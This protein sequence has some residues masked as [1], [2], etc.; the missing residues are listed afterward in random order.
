MLPAEAVEDL[1]K[2]LANLDTT[3]AEHAQL[4][5][6]KGY[7]SVKMLKNATFDDLKELGFITPV[8]RSITTREGGKSTAP[9]T[10]DPQIYTTGAHI[11]MTAHKNTACTTRSTSHRPYTS[12]AHM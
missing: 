10:L 6:Q 8:A 11:P 12:H 3:L 4:L 2:Y 1:R 9:T 7:K 5:Y